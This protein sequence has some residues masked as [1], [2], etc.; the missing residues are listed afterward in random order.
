MSLVIEIYLFVLMAGCLITVGL[1]TYYRIHARRVKAIAER[2]EIKMNTTTKAFWAF[3]TLMVVI[4]VIIWLC[5][6]YF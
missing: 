5:V 1:M 3:L 6:M 4:A 2:C